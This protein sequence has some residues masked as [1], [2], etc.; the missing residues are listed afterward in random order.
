MT[1]VVMFGS[2]ALINMDEFVDLLMKFG[3][4]SRDTL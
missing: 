4:V 3:Y 2:A 1:S